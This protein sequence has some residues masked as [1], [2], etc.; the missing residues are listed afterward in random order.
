MPFNKE[1]E[2]AG[3]FFRLHG[4]CQAV[5]LHGGWV[6]FVQRVGL[7]P[8]RNRLLDVKP[9]AN[10]PIVSRCSSLPHRLRERTV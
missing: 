10:A 3:L 8:E 7:E 5:L 1:R 9:G 2:S 6:N 4:H